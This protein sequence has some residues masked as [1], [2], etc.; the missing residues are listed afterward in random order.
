[1][2]REDEDLNIGIA[3]GVFLG[4]PITLFMFY[5]GKENLD[6]IE[7]ET[8]LVGTLATLG[9][10]ATVWMIRRQ[11]AF[12]QKKHDEHGIAKRMVA[13][14]ELNFALS[15]LCEHAER[16]IGNVSQGKKVERFSGHAIEAL[17]AMVEYGDQKIQFRISKLFQKLQVA[18]S[19]ASEPANNITDKA[20]YS[21]NYMEVYCVASSLYGYARLE[22]DEIRPIE[23]QEL[24]FNPIFFNIKTVNLIDE[25]N[26]QADAYRKRVITAF[27]F[28]D[29]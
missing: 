2:K 23:T 22:I 11:I 25:I 3:F 28:I 4:V 19:R 15:E 26:R 20:T 1:M 8:L 13:R 24:N 5:L 29:S 16:S 7:W 17:K 10:A 27:T 6:H 9:A 21:L 18:D 12:E 14:A